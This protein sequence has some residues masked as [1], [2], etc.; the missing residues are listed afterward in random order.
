[1]HNQSVQNLN[2]LT[3][4]ISMLSKEKLNGGQTDGR[5]VKPENYPKYK[6][7]KKTNINIHICI[8]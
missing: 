7:E 5:N 2:L 3:P 6:K 8:Q 4:L 1:M